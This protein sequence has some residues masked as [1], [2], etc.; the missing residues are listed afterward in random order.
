[1]TQGTPPTS[2]RWGRLRRWASAAQ[3]P[4]VTMVALG[5]VLVATGFGPSAVVVGMPI[6]WG[7]AWATGRLGRWLWAPLPSAAYGLPEEPPA[8]AGPP[9]G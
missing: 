7:A 1:M 6:G 2:G 8:T 4:V 9:P 3:T 5:T